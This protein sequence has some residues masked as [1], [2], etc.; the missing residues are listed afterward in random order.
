[1]NQI[2]HELIAI[3]PNNKHKE[4]L[5]GWGDNIRYGAVPADNANYDVIREL[6]GDVDIPKEGNF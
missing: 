2:R 4:M 3:D 1:M 6:L 5:A